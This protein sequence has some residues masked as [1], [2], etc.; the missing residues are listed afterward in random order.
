MG[1]AIF[2]VVFGVVFGVEFTV[3]FGCIFGA[4]F[5]AV[6]R[7]VVSFWM[8]FLRVFQFW[9]FGDFRGIFAAFTRVVGLFVGCI[10]G[11]I[12]GFSA[13]AGKDRRTTRCRYIFSTFF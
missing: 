11:F 7:V 10:V 1:F 8:F 5:S 6:F 3:A 4:V 13:I 2:G 12:V 9:A